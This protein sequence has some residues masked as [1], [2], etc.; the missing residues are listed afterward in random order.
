MISELGYQLSQYHILGP[1][2]FALGHFFRLRQEASAIATDE[3][4][5]AAVARVNN[6]SDIIDKLLYIF[7]IFSK[8]DDYVRDN[9]LESALF[10]ELFR[11]IKR[12]EPNQ[13][14]QLL[15]FFSQYQRHPKASLLY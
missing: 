7:V 1:L 8:M 11:L 3:G 2:V 5:A 9:M 14:V 12:M 15:K 6:V 13:Q 10:V 4:T